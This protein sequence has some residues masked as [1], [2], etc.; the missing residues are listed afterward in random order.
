[1][2]RQNNLDWVVVQDIDG[3]QCRL[4]YT[5]TSAAENAMYQ[6]IGHA[7]SDDM[8]NWTRMEKWSVFGYHG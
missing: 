4:F 3:G 8:H 1:M 6:R 5:G 7:T 2:G